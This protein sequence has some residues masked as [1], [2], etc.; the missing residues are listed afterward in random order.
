MA[1]A[2]RHGQNGT[3]A[4]AVTIGYVDCLGRITLMVK[5]DQKQSSAADWNCGAIN[6]HPAAGHC[7]GDDQAALNGRA[8]DH[9]GAIDDGCLALLGG[10]CHHRQQRNRE[11]KQA[12]IGK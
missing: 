8:G 5:S 9:I 6:F 12:E 11:K 2:L 1:V 3:V 7:A 4:R 10:A